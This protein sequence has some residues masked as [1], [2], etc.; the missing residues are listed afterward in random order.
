[1]LESVESQAILSWLFALVAM[2]AV[3]WFV[4]GFSQKHTTGRTLEE[5]LAIRASR[6]ARLIVIAALAAAACYFLDVSKP[7]AILFIPVPE[8]FLEPAG[9]LYDLTFSVICFTVVASVEFQL[10]YARLAPEHRSRNILVLI[11]SRT[12]GLLLF[13][14]LSLLLGL[15]GV[16]VEEENFV[17]RHLQHFVMNPGAFLL[18]SLVTLG[19]QLLNHRQVL[20]AKRTVQD[21]LQKIHVIVISY[22][23]VSLVALHVLSVT[24]AFVV[25]TL[26]SFDEWYMMREQ[27]KKLTGLTAPEGSGDPIT[28]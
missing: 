4:L 13:L 21:S 20:L 9:I 1:M 3:L 2:G 17:S 18:I 24:A 28:S 22:V 8:A 10:S 7:I 27:K 11:G 19:N 16:R 25:F 15:G 14:A 12:Y 6:N 23:T 5:V 26:F